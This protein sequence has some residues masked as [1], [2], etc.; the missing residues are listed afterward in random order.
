MA[1]HD[2]LWNALNEALHNLL[3]RVRA[4]LS[5]KEINDIKEYIY[6]REY[7]LALELICFGL[8]EKATQVEPE[9]QAEIGRL[10]TL[11]EIDPRKL[12]AK[13]G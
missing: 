4:S 3:F 13:A 11:M 6:A 8:A 5:D 1:K 2:E 7:G 9:V 12:P 10:A